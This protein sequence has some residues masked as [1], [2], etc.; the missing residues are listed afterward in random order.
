MDGALKHN[1]KRKKPDTEDH[2]LYDM[3]FKKRPN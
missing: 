3:K 2:I 1:V